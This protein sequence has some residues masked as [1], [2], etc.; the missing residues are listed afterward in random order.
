[1]FDELK[2]IPGEKIINNC[3]LIQRT[4]NHAGGEYD[5]PGM[6]KVGNS[7]CPE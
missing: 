7:F 6:Q 1:M 5:C 4:I 3:W 2:K